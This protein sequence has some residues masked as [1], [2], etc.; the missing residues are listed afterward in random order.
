VFNKNYIRLHLIESYRHSQLL[1]SVTLHNW[2]TF[3]VPAF[4]LFSIQ[5]VL[6]F[7]L[8][9]GGDET[10]VNNYPIFSFNGG[11]LRHKSFSDTSQRQ[12]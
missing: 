7:N 4:L 9:N 1:P 6:H 5:G 8:K 11:P 12:G 3:S 2:A 10:I